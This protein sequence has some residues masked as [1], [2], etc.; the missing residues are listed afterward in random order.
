[1]LFLNSCMNCTN[2]GLYQVIDVTENAKNGFH[3]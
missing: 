1:M 2:N 3:E